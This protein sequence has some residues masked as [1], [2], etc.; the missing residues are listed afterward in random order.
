MNVWEPAENE[1]GWNLSSAGI[2]GHSHY[3]RKTCGAFVSGGSLI[4]RAA[5]VK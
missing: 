4:A 3:A 5:G 2:F 1:S